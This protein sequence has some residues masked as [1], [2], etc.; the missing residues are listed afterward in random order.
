M[1]Q[2]NDMR[3]AEA[4]DCE[5]GDSDADPDFVPTQFLDDDEKRKRRT[6]LDSDA[7][8]TEHIRL[9]VSS[10][11]SDTSSISLDYFRRMHRNMQNNL[12]EMF[13][14]LVAPGQEQE[15][16]DI[17]EKQEKQQI[18]NDAILT[19]LKEAFGMCK[20]RT[21]RRSALMLISKE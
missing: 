12:T 13:C 11:L 8:N 16:R 3:S 5:G 14:K 4:M 10:N 18:E 7:L 20:P 15:M 2:L 19:H 1:K 17:L 9:Q 6:Q 21:S